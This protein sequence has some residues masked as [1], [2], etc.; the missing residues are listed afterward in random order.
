MSDENKTIVLRYCEDF[1]GKGKKDVAD[2]L[3]SKNFI[4][5]G[6]GA[7]ESVDRESYIQESVEYNKFC[8]DT[9][10][11]A[12]DIIAEGNKVVIRGTWSGKHIGG[13]F[14]A[15]P[16]DRRLTINIINILQLA[17]GEIVEE[18][19]GSDYLL[20]VK[21]QLGLIPTE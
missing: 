1:W 8:V 7:E 19:E 18:W 6:P 21:Q 13:L 9:R 14:D 17:D 3:L 20:D 10:F 12:E 15:P 2:E 11:F 5:H 4:Y 16:T